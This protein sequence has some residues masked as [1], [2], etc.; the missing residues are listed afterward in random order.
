MLEGE[1]QLLECSGRFLGS[2]VRE[3]VRVCMPSLGKIV[4]LGK[5][6]VEHPPKSEAARPGPRMQAHF[7]PAARPSREGGCAK[8]LV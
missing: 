1:L 2:W 6:E 4:A 3:S 5:I 8:M 7:K